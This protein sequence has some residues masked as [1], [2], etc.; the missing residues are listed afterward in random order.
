MSSKLL[1]VLVVDDDV[2]MQ[3]LIKRILEIE[4][5][6][7]ITAGTGETALQSLEEENPD[8][9]LL[10]IMLPDT[11]GYS[12]CRKIRGFSQTPIIMVSAK[13][14]EKEIVEGLNT[15]AD[16]Y[17]IKPFSATELVARIKA[18]LR[19]TK[20]PV[21][22]RCSHFKYHNLLID[23]ASQ[24][25]KVAEKEI[26]LTHT[27]YKLLSYISRNAGQI[28]TPNQLLYKVWGEEYTG[29]FHLLQV[30]IARLRQKL[31]DNARHPVYIH[32]RHGLG[33]IMSSHS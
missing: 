9:I 26:E 4:K 28:I 13:N 18:V 20:P 15:G 1:Q 31:G 6:R 23:F 8:L 32:T 12:I 19:R 33:Y 29:A 2:W 27:E 17:I 16:D 11:T 22:Q 30:H 25:V 3:R 21:T 24:R 10:D 7:V 14:S 5:S